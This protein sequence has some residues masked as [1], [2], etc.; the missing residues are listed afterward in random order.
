MEKIACPFCNESNPERL[1][2]VN[3][4]K[5]L[6]CDTCGRLFSIDTIPFPSE[7]YLGKPSESMIEER[8]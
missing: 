7:D 6:R 1:I 2:I 3:E 8:R 4:G 5:L